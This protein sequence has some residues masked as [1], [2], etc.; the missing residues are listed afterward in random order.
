MV[1]GCSMKIEPSFKKSAVFNGLVS[2]TTSGLDKI[3]WNWWLGVSLCVS[4]AWA[5][6]YLDTEADQLR[7]L[8]LVPQLKLWWY[9]S[10]TKS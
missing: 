5:Y 6:H 8:N 10:N 4:L 3:Q 9:Q 7:T 1:E 2:S